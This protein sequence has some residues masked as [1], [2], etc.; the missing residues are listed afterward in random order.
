MLTKSA[1]SVDVVMKSA[2]NAPQNVEQTLV[3][4]RQCS[5]RCR[6]PHTRVQPS[7]VTRARTRDDRAKM[8]DLDQIGGDFYGAGM[9]A[10]PRAGRRAAFTLNT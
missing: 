2:C 9:G 1:C 6:Q 7:E 8:A 3:C 10:A 4:G 5:H